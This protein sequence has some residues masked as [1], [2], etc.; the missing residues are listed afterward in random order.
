MFFQYYFSKMNFRIRRTDFNRPLVFVLTRLCCNSYTVYVLCTYHR[1]VSCG[2]TKWFNDERNVQKCV[3]SSRFLVTL[4]T[5]HIVFHLPLIQVVDK[6]RLQEETI[7]TTT[8]TT[9]TNLFS[10]LKVYLK[11]IKHNST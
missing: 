3:V 1:Y 8:T 6:T 10:S 2:G 11:S 5:F 4:Q 7:T 9:T